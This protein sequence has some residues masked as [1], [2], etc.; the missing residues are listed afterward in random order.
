MPAPLFACWKP[1]AVIRKP[2]SNLLQNTYG[3]LLSHWQGLA[4]N[5]QRSVETTASLH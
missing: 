4:L 5:R 3:R 2:P 1:S